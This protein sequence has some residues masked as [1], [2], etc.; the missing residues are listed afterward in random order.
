MIKILKKNFEN[1]IFDTSA[2]SKSGLGRA[3]TDIFNYFQKVISSDKK[4][5]FDYQLGVETCKQFSLLDLFRFN[6]FS[7][8][9][10]NIYVFTNLFTPS[11]WIFKIKFVFILFDLYCFSENGFKSF[12]LRKL[13]LIFLKN[14]TSVI[15]ATKTIKDEAIELFKY[16]VINYEDKVLNADNVFKNLRGKNIC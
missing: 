2:K 5:Y 1:L 16:E 11:M 8:N 6:R 12:L 7:N 3:R 14:A 15:C 13:T 10:K 9:K 4:I